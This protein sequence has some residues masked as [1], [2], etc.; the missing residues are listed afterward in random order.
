MHECMDNKKPSSISQLWNRSWTW[1]AGTGGCV[2]KIPLA[3][4]SNSPLITRTRS[5]LT[6]WVKG[7]KEWQLHVRSDYNFVIGQLDPLACQ[8]K[9][10]R[11]PFP[12]PRP[13]PRH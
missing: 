2:L 10:G 8:Q 7:D 13:P 1:D 12:S 9:W 4:P 3:L 11:K 5:D 6:A